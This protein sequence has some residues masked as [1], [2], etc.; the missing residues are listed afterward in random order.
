[1]CDSILIA[2]DGSPEAKSALK[3]GLDLAAKLQA[4][5]TLVSILEPFPSYLNIAGSVAPELPAT[6]LRE[7]RDELTELQS[8]THQEATRRNIPLQTQLLE[9]PEVSGI[10]NAA[11]ET[12]AR[13]IVI[14]L[15]RHSATLEWAGTIR[16]VANESPRPIL[17]VPCNRDPKG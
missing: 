13:L 14:G 2:Y 4:S 15:R 12:H 6:M 11:R 5:V 8:M 17:A 10:L 7:H 1:M 16:Q 3:V 9:A